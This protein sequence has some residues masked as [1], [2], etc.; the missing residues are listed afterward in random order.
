MTLKNADDLLTLA[1][2]RKEWIN[3]VDNIY[4]AAKSSKEH[5]YLTK[6]YFYYGF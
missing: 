1:Q 6:Y 2:D 5:L 4:V 3:F